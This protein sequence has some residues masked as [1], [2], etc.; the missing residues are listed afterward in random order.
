MFHGKKASRLEY[1][2]ELA[3][4]APTPRGFKSILTKGAGSTLKAM[5]SLVVTEGARKLR[6]LAP[7]ASQQDGTD[8]RTVSCVL[9]KY[10]GPHTIGFAVGSYDRGKE[11]VIDPVVSYA[12]SISAGSSTTVAAIAADA[13]GDLIMTGSTYGSNYPVVNGLPKQR[14]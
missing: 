5:G 14:C 1:D 2:F 4:N 6:V 11:L 7:A 12:T 3:P 9:H 13:S 8:V 10:F